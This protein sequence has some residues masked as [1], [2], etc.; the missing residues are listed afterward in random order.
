MDQKKRIDKILSAIEV[1]SQKEVGALLGAELQLTGISPEIVTKEEAFENVIGKQICA[2][3]DIVGEV[4]GKGCLLVGIKDAIRLG[5]TLIMLPSS[6]LDEVIGREEYSEEIDD[7]YGEIANIIAG[8]FTKDFEEMYHKS[9]RFIRK[10]LEA[11]SPGKIDLS[12]DYFSSTTSYYQVA[13]TMKLDGKQMGELV[14]L[15]P[16][17]PFG[18]EPEKKI[19]IWKQ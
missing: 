2:Y 3:M 15:M 4:E 18:L 1:R 9:V 11:I 14:M 12:S 8:S 10:E 19:S 6:E 7:S 13:Y 16:A 17:A 5:G